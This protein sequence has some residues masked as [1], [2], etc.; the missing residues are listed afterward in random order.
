VQ[1]ATCRNALPDN[2]EHRL[3]RE[4][5]RARREG[6]GETKDAS[7]RTNRLDDHPLDDYER[8][9]TSLDKGEQNAIY[10]P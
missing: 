7:P 2:Q 4:R 1:P 10:L 3:P 9:D 5:G 8:D 6:G